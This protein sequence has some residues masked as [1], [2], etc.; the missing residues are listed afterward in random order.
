MNRIRVMYM[1]HAFEVGGVEDLVLSL[2]RHLP[3]RFEPLVCAIHDLGAI[4]REIR[5]ARVPV[6][7]L[8]LNPGLRRPWDLARMRHFLRQAQ[9]QIVHTFLLTASLY[10]RLAA[11]LARVPI[12]IGTEQNIYHAKHP[13]HALAERLLMAGTARVVASAESVRDHYIRSLHV[14]PAKVD[15]IYNA[16]DWE[17]LRTTAGRAE[18]RRSMGIPAGAPA[19]AAIGR[20]TEQKGHTYLFDALA[21]TDALGH[22]HL[23]VAGDGELREALCDRARALGIGARVHFLGI[24]RDVGNVLSAADVFVLPSLWEGLPLALVLAMGAGVPAVATSV[25]GVPEIVDHG[26]TGV[27]VPPANS[28]ELGGAISRLLT[29]PALQRRIAAAACA[30]LRPR[31]GVDQYVC[32]VT[33]LYDRLLTGRAA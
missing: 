15:V 2:V 12:V 33:S 5:D 22:V 14:N 25:G 23:I 4:G 11:M 1:A 10:G 27:L 6:T 13:R 19:I 9:P 17:H 7:V 30:S 26:R 31:F 8:G 28:A 29:D 16:V 20:L 24:R 3:D 32:S 18:I 21:Q